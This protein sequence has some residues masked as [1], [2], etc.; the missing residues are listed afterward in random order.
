MLKM[1]EYLIF[2][3]ITIKMK[4]FDFINIAYYL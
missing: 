3:F 1:W 2:M 4:L